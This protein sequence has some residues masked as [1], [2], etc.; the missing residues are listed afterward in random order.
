MQVYRLIACYLS[1]A[2]TYFEH[3]EVCCSQEEEMVTFISWHRLQRY[4][5]A[6]IKFKITSRNLIA[7]L[8]LFLI[9]L[10]YNYVVR[11]KSLMYNPSLLLSSVAWRLLFQLWTTSVK[12]RTVFYSYFLL[13]YI[14]SLWWGIPAIKFHLGGICELYLCK[15]N[16]TKNTV[17]LLRKIHIGQ[18]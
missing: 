4:F 2:S 12:T 15:M 3:C 9:G 18:R 1:L 8:R 5:P 11:R 13:T 14:G 10:A 7:N 17:Y 16:F 6:I